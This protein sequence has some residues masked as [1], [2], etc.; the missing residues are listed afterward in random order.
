VQ[1]LA[2][3]I[4]EKINFVQFQNNGLVSCETKDIPQKKRGSHL[5]CYCRQWDFI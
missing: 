2:D 5:F 4:Q 3:I 1:W